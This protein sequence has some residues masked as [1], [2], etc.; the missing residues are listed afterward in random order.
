VG[1]VASLL[2]LLKR[3]LYFSFVYLFNVS[4]VGRHKVRRSVLA[5]GGEADFEVQH[6]VAALN[7]TGSTKLQ[8]S[9][10]S[11]FSPNAC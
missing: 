6:C 10:E 5:L 4:I 11:A 8:I 2:I 7:L 3:W 1:G 9:T